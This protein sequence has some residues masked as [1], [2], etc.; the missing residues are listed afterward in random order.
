VETLHADR[1]TSKRCAIL[2]GTGSLIATYGVIAKI[3]EPTEVTSAIAI[4]AVLGFCSM[5]SAD[6]MRRP[7]LAFAGDVIRWRKWPLPDRVVRWDDV[8]Y[9]EIAVHR[10]RGNV[11]SEMLTIYLTTGGPRRVSAALAIESVLGL[12]PER[13]FD[14]IAE[15]A[16]RAGADVSWLRL[17]KR[18]LRRFSVLSAGRRV[19]ARAP[20]RTIGVALMAAVWLGLSAV[21]TVSGTSLT[22]D[23]VLIALGVGLYFAITILVLPGRWMVDGD[24]L[25]GPK[26]ARLALTQVTEASVSRDRDRHAFLRI[27]GH[28]DE[29]RVPVAWLPLRIEDFL[30]DIGLEFAHPWTW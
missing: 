26:G 1:G 16:T 18:P 27:K 5:R 30:R 22:P 6:R 29:V 2:C 9:V 15:R 11:G 28:A 13:G 4:A 21:I 19:V 3:G 10:G 20:R 14:G 7:A 8:R 24:V 25:L 17:P 23:R 12:G